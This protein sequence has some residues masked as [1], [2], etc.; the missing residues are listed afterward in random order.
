[1]ARDQC[2]WNGSRT[3]DPYGLWADLAERSKFMIISEIIKPRSTY[4][5]KFFSKTWKIPP[6][7]SLIQELHWT[8]LGSWRCQ[9][10]FNK[11][12]HFL[13]THLELQY[14]QDRKNRN[15]PERPSQLFSMGEKWAISCNWY[16]KRKHFDLQPKSWKKN[17]HSWQAHKKDHFRSMEL[18]QPPCIGLWGQ[19]SLHQHLRWRYCSFSKP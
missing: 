14:T 3:M 2:C 16:C 18:R 9:S 1:M 4:Q 5:G 10:S 17:S 15:K 12:C 7:I 19:N 8:R 6:L 13:H 11:W